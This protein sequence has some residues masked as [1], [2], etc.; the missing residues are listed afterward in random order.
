MTM[1]AKYRFQVALL[2]LLAGCAMVGPRFSE[3]PAST[4]SIPTNSVHLI[5]FSLHDKEYFHP[6]YATEALI[7][8]DGVENG[9]VAVGSFRMLT[10]MPG[11]HRLAAHYRFWSGRCDV[12]VDLE[13]GMR[14]FAEV[15]PWFSFTHPSAKPAAPG[16]YSALNLLAWIHPLGE[17]AVMQSNPCGGFTIG[18][19]VEAAALPKLANLPAWP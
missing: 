18:L 10:L 9:A 7:E 12:V 3:H 4:A 17:M 15:T 13:G 19:E 14:Y 5:I 16:E 11:R 1:R 8:I 6:Y 2:V